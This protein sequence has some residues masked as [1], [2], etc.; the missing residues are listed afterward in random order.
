MYSAHN[1]Y[2][3]Y[4]RAR[5]KFS[6]KTYLLLFLWLILAL[7]QW[8]VVCLVDSIREI[9]W[10]HYYISIAAF[11]IA[12]LLFAL[13]LFFENLRFNNVV[14]FIMSFFIVELQI[15]ATFALVARAYWA[16]ML[17]YFCICAVLLFIFV[18]IGIALPRKMDLTLH[19]ALLF[20]LAFLFLLIAVF[21]LML[22]LIVPECEGYAYVLV[23]IPISI[24]MLFFVM[25]HAQ[26]IHGRRFAEM[27]LHD[28]CLGS[29]ILFHDFLIIFWLTIY[30][31]VWGRLVTPSDWGTTEA[32]T[33]ASARALDLGDDDFAV[34]Y[35]T[36]PMYMPKRLN[37]FRPTSNCETTDLTITHD[38]MPNDNKRLTAVP[39]DSNWANIWAES[40]QNPAQNSPASDE[41][42]L[43]ANIE[44]PSPSPANE[45]D[46]MS[47]ADKSSTAEYIFDE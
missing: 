45:A 6:V 20:I 32:K 4:R 16:E 12:I 28:Y 9:F 5:K 41:G 42:I 37:Q 38:F 33:T 14:G 36:K 3:A 34:D 30:W 29:L 39:K 27:R 13:F 7:V 15:I 1:V 10:K 47:A 23:Q 22:H 46:D 35:E 25:Y 17:M 18:A 11:L 24:T 43:D 31:Q 19:V 2:Y 8:V 21:F 26:T 40:R 44:E